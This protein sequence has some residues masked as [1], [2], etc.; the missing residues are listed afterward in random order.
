MPNNPVRITAGTP[1]RSGGGFKRSMIAL[2]E[3]IN[4]FLN[5]ILLILGGAFLVSMCA[6]TC[7]NILLRLGWAPI[8]GT[9]ELMGFFGAVAAAFALGHTQNRRGHIAVDVLVQ[10]FS[11]RIRK[12]LQIFNAGVCAVFFSLATWQVVK[13][14]IVLLETGELTETLRIIYYPFTF[15]VAL[16]CAVL[17]LVFL[18]DLIKAA[19]P[20]KE[21]EP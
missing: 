7:A 20:W 1:P 19:V 11:R 8:R 5:R 14:G 2:L 13:K 12:M 6:L 9:F 21:R 16:G 10:S 18:L 17:V 3:K 4:F 15:A